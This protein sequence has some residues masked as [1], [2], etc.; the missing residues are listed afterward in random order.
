M[1]DVQTGERMPKRD[2]GVGEKKKA[3]E[4]KK[5]CT[6]RGGERERNR[7]EQKYLE[8]RKM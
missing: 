6:E 7:E 4:S 3:R 1:L 2:K 5:E 8:K